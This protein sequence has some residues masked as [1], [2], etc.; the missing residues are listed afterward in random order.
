MTSEELLK[1]FDKTIEEAPV[2]FWVN[3]PEFAAACKREWCKEV[4]ELRKELETAI[5]ERDTLKLIVTK[6]S[7]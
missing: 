3:N 7:N 2:N 6:K 1:K 4:A 5:T